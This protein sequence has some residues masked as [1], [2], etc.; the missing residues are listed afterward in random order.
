MSCYSRYQHDVH[1]VHDRAVSVIP[2]TINQPRS[3]H[4]NVL[5][6]ITEAWLHK[7]P[8]RT[9]YC[10]YIAKLVIVRINELY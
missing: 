3:P 6:K 7:L 5:L 9:V 10:T 1:D 2:T 4:I 8:K